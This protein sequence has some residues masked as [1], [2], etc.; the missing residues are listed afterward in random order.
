M[1]LIGEK[2]KQ[3]ADADRPM[4]RHAERK[5]AVTARLVNLSVKHTC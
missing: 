5:G 2:K 3:G 4:R 1:N